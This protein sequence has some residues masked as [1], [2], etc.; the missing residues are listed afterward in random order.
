MATSAP[1]S[2]AVRRLVLLSPLLLFILGFAAEVREGLRARDAAG[3]VV[4]DGGFWR[5]V[6][7]A[8]RTADL[9]LDSGRLSLP[10]SV[11][12]EFPDRPRIREVRLHG[13]PSES[14]G[15]LGLRY[16]AQDGRILRVSIDPF[17]PVIVRLLVERDGRVGLPVLQ[18]QVEDL[19]GRGE[20]LDYRLR[21]D[22]DRTRV[23]IAGRLVLEA[24][25]AATVDRVFIEDCRFALSSIG[26]TDMEG[27]AIDADFAALRPV[28]AA[29][30]FMQTAGPLAALHLIVMAFLMALCLGRP[31][32]WKVG[33]AALVALASWN[34]HLA[35]AGIDLPWLATGLLVLAPLGVI[36]GLFVLRDDLRVGEG[37][38][39]CG[40]PR[41]VIA[42]VVLIT[43]YIVT[44]SVYREL[45]LI[46]S[47][48]LAAIQIEQA[49]PPDPT[50]P[51]EDVTAPDFALD[52]L[53]HRS[54]GWSFR[55]FDFHASVTFGEGAVLELRSRSDEDAAIGVAALVSAN[56]AFSSG[57]YEESNQRFL[58]SSEATG[59]VTIAAGETRAIQFSARGRQFHLLV[60]GEEI[61]SATSATYLRGRFTALAAAGV[62]EVRNMR[63][64]PT[65][66]LVDDVPT[67]LG[68]SAL[69]GVAPLCY[70]ALL[71]ALLFT[72][73][74]SSASSVRA[75]AMVEAA[76]FSLVPFA[77]L[78][79]VFGSVHTPS[80][81]LVIAS[82]GSA[83]VLLV[84]ASLHCARMNAPRFV[85]VGI[86]A[87][88]GAFFTGQAVTLPAPIPTEPAARA[89]YLNARTH[90]DAVSGPMHADFLHLQHPLIRRFNQYLVDHRLRDRHVGEG[91]V[92]GSSASRR[93]VCLGSS[94]T[95]GYLLP[96]GAGQDYPSRLQ[97][98]LRASGHDVQ[99]WNAAWSGATTSRI[100]WFLRNVL[101]PL[102][103]DVVTLS[104]SYN[105]AYILSQGDE[106]R[107]FERLV[108]E[109]PGPWET[110]V[111]R[112]RVQRDRRIFEN[113]RA[114]FE[115]GE[116]DSMSC[117]VEHGGDATDTP[118]A[119]FERALR[120]I[121]TLAEE[122][123]FE[124]VLIK[125]AI[126][127]NRARI[128]K[129]EFRA[130][131]DA[132]AAECGLVVCDPT[133]VMLQAERRLE[134][135]VFMD[136]VHLNAIGCT[137]M[138]WSLAP[139]VEEALR[140]GAGNSGDPDVGDP[141]DLGSD[142]GGGP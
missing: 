82:A 67:P 30:V 43:V 96:K 35:C 60:D 86:V 10:S 103:P 11:H 98:R 70:L 58:A 101:A 16:A 135:P 87:G 61:A 111:E 72:F 6:D 25:T 24:A 83:M 21:F 54:F 121:A 2:L 39:P 113:A 55:D 40:R 5:G 114:L 127:G 118:A 77:W 69:A 56:P 112:A 1:Q 139:H 99:V 36:P 49:T 14:I 138:A 81:E 128:W 32:V 133:H 92:P 123:G 109:P 15:R 134:E 119:R 62:L 95:Y 102:H 7:A 31:T 28:S 78:I 76:S 59:T 57:I 140:R 68:R 84:V 53:S 94:S 50:V 130:A 20:G 51:T 79:A 116:K 12:L 131:I 85:L 8:G 47:D 13:R 17:G 19:A 33:F 100:Y 75:L 110:F 105:D 88:S 107:W 73:L 136:E 66:A 104:V 89:A 93:V 4:A 45:A 80:L 42:A 71:C 142:P 91:A 44:S 52:A 97:E 22:E 38:R 63:I 117:W 120:R 108:G 46:R 48:E 132:V 141:G 18:T 90:A 74:G 126:A 37:D 23:F 64:S 129:D 27:V 29:V 122:R 125:E 124:L 106:G 3:L 41:V 65:R 137:V 26:L 34:A 9:A 115:L